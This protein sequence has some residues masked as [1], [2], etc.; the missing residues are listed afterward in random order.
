MGGFSAAERQQVWLHHCGP[1]FSSKCSIKWCTNVISVFQFHCGHDI[2]ESK[3][4]SK[5][6]K[7]IFPICS[8]CNLSMGT[9]SIRAWNRRYAPSFECKP[10]VNVHALV[11]CIIVAL[12]FCGAMYG[13][14][15][16]PVLLPCAT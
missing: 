6:M 14:E 2:P 10:V 16:P 12:I 7:N 5:N 4:G 3:G 15:S 11:S 9:T 8:S 13:L 1:I